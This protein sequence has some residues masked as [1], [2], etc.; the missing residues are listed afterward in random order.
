M[1]SFLDISTYIIPQVCLNVKTRERVCETKVGVFN[2]IEKEE[3][4]YLLPYYPIDLASG[5]TV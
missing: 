5:L 2:T 1:E 3:D 4:E